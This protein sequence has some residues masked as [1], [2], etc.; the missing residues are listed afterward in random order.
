[1]R[2]YFADQ[3]ENKIFE[4]LLIEL[5][6]YCKTFSLIWRNEYYDCC[7]KEYHDEVIANLE[8]FMVRQER[9]FAWPGTK[10]AGDIPA[11]QY[12]F[13]FTEESL[14]V[15]LKYL[16]F[17]SC[18]GFEDFSLQ[19]QNN[20]PVLTTISHEHTAWLDMEDSV[21]QNLIQEIPLLKDFLVKSETC[22]P[23]YAVVRI[24]HNID[25]TSCC[26]PIGIIRFFDTEERAD[27]FC[28]ALEE[29]KSSECFH[30]VVP[31]FGEFPPI[32]RSI[33]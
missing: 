21:C 9:V 29:L 20:I 7:W 8:P 17:Y 16:S 6:D 31:F 24:N 19:D 5:L 15:L 23:S 25:C 13:D 22:N 10:I 1:M 27:A 2:Y 26:H 3:I 30:M 11:S 14:N 4:L 12:T 32:P 18:W 33:Q 28:E